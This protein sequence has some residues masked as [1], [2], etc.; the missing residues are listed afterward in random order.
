MIAVRNLQVLCYWWTL[1]RISVIINYYF[2][3]NIIIGHFI[4]IIIFWY[5]VVFNYRYFAYFTRKI[6]VP[7][8]TARCRK[9]PKMANSARNFAAKMYP[10]QPPV[11]CSLTPSISVQMTSNARIEKNRDS[12]CGCAR[13]ASEKDK[14]TTDHPFS[15][16]G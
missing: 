5:T 16:I 2:A 3:F 8:D 6:F 11:D 13:V 7:Q 14:Y 1:D 10:S 9:P 12:V 4:V 15:V